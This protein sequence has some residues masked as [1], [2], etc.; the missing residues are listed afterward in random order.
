MKK[1]KVPWKHRMYYQRMMMKCQS[2]EGLINQTTISRSI[3]LNIQTI[4][5]S[6]TYLNLHS[7]LTKSNNHKISKSQNNR[8]NSKRRINSKTKRKR[9]QLQSLL[10]RLDWTRQNLLI[11]QQK[12]KRKGWSLSLWIGLSPLCL[13]V[14]L[15]LPQTKWINRSCSIQSYPKSSYSNCTTQC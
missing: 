4:S 9:N 3:R 5:L 14:G 10:N 1:Y 8:I 7:K 12:T 15:D 13:K 2:S 11:G 6:K